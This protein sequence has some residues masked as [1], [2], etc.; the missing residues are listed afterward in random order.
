MHASSAGGRPRHLAVTQELRAVLNL[1][2]LSQVPS[3]FLGRRGHLWAAAAPRISDSQ[4]PSP[5]SSLSFTP[6]NSPRQP[7]DHSN[8]LVKVWSITV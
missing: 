1:P 6:I 7:A 3:G 2:A 8:L 4:L 5:P